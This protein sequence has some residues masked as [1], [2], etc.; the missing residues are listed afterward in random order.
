MLAVFNGYVY[1]LIVSSCI[2]ILFE[3]THICKTQ[4]T[5]IL[6]ARGGK[7]ISVMRWC[8]CS[9]CCLATVITLLANNEILIKNSKLME[10]FIM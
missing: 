6:F 9:S 10:I 7:C 4:Y 5:N 3:E 2:F 1:R 8:L